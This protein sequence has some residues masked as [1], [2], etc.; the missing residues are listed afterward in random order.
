MTYLV[1]SDVAVKTREG[2]KTLRKGQMVKIPE[3][4]ARLLIEK[5]K[6]ELY[7]PEPQP[8]V[9][10]EQFESTFLNAV[11]EISKNYMPGVIEYSRQTYPER[12]ENGIEAEN[13]LNLLWNNDI[14]SFRKAVAEWRGIN[15]EMIKLF[16]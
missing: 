14:E 7:E 5:G 6:L 8:E 4:S 1:I 16:G 13:R 10:P 15:L 9:T 11:D 12:Y 3:Q 2:V